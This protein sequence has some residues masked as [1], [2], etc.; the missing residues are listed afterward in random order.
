MSGKS[1]AQQP[2]TEV[3]SA[4]SDPIRWSI[5]AQAAKVDELAAIT[6]ESTLP[7]A[8]PTISYH[9]K[10]LQNAGLIST[11]K[12][13]RNY[14]YTLR[15]DV[16]ESLADGLWELAPTPRPVIDGQK[17]RAS[18]RRPGQPDQADRLAAPRQRAVNDD[19][20]EAVVLTW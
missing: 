18:R 13:G 11:R 17:G 6:L 2:P 19:V 16:I 4:L 3:F 10:I 12:A 15:R 8:K 20:E 5:I 9:I 7:V 14:Y 1:T